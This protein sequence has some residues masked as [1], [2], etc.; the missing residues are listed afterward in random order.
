MDVTRVIMAQTIGG[1]C[2]G[3][4]GGQPL[5]VLLSTAPL[6]LYIKIIYTISQTYHINFYAMYGCIGLFNS[7]FL[8]IYSVCGFSRWMKWSTRSTEEIFAMFVSMAFAYDA[9]NDLY[10]T[11][12]ENY[13]CKSSINYSLLNETQ[14]FD[15]SF[16]NSTDTNGRI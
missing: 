8:I 2:Y 12:K 9:G 13:H 15:K 11:F 10:A 5:I 16:V 4:F 3:V 7:L 6:A 1:L 14:E